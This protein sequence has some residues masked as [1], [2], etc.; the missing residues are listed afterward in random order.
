M[1][2]LQDE[3]IK[4]RLREAENGE[5]IRN[6]TQKVSDLEQVTAAANKK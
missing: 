3:L 5:R 2:I 6:L 4:E 1:F